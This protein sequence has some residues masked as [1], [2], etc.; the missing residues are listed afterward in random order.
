M[1]V[2]MTT[3]GRDSNRDS[4]F[5]HKKTFPYMKIVSR[6]KRTLLSTKEQVG[7]DRTVT[8]VICI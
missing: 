1:Q 4:M 6:N 8:E 7:Q 3:R 2:G 5:F